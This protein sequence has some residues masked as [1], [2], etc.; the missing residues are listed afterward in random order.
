MSISSGLSRFGNEA[1]RLRVRHGAG[2]C[3]RKPRY[4]RKFDDT[5]LFVRVWAEIPRVII[6]RLLHRVQ[7]P[8]H[9]PGLLGQVVN[10]QLDAVPLLPRYFVPRRNEGIEAQRK[11]VQLV[12]EVMPSALPAP[13]PYQRSRR[14][15]DL[16]GRRADHRADVHPVGM[17]ADEFSMQSSRQLR[18]SAGIRSISFSRTYCDRWR[19]PTRREEVSDLT[20]ATPLL[21]N[22]PF[23]TSSRLLT[24]FSIPARGFRP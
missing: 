11:V 4:A 6:Q 9:V 24:E 7:H 18:S 17:A 12:F 16:I 14:D 1:D 3:L 10:F 5:R 8:R 20:G 22:V 23:C 19:R 13:L 21:K 2:K 15:G